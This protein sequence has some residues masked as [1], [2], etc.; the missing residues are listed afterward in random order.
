LIGCSSGGKNRDCRSNYPGADDSRRPTALRFEAAIALKSQR[1]LMVELI[2]VRKSSCLERLQL[3]AQT[4]E[5][6]ALFGVEQQQKQ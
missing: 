6:L 2:F 3:K 1:T 5:D 4:S